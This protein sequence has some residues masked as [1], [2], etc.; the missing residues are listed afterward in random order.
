MSI[1]IVRPDDWHVHFRQG[2][3]LVNVVNYTAARFGRAL[4]MPNTKPPICTV[5]EAHEYEQAIRTACSHRFKPLF[6][7]YL[8]TQ[9]TVDDVR[10]AAEI[11]EIPGYKLYP[12]GA[13]TNSDFGIS[14]DNL[15]TVYP[16]LGAIADRNLTLMIHGE[17]P[18]KDPFDREKYFIELILAKILLEFGDNLRITFE[19]ITTQEGVA[20]VKQHSNIAATVTAHHLLH[21]R[22]ALFEEGLSPHHYCLPVLK[23]EKDRKIILDAAINHDRFFLGT[24]SAP[25]PRRLKESRKAPAGCFTAPVGIELYA[26]AFDQAWALDHLEA[27]ASRRGAAWYGLNPN[28]DTIRLER[29]TPPEGEPNTYQEY[30]FIKGDV[31]VCPWSDV[32]DRWKVVEVTDAQ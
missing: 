14:V 18:G 22:G 3:R 1:E 15:H 16:I 23:T 27:F 10:A 30:D 17:I 26:E 6:A 24:D 13:T 8:T 31:A 12:L 29:S 20:I 21:N 25:H 11:P 7:L 32:A 9:T 28:P 5:A 4:V 19:H 2:A